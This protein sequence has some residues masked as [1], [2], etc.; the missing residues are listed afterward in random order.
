MVDYV[1]EELGIEPKLVIHRKLDYY[2]AEGRKYL[3]FLKTELSAAS[4]NNI[5]ETIG[6]DGKSYPFNSDYLVVVIAMTDEE[7][8]PKKLYYMRGVG[9]NVAFVLL[10]KRLKKVFRPNCL[11]FPLKFSYRKLTSIIEDAL[12]GLIEDSRK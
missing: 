2:W 5:L 9:E 7:H 12:Y 4:F 11:I 3:C 6:D 8:N 1:L 10:N